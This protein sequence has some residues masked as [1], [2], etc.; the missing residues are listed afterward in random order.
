MQDLSQA[1]RKTFPPFLRLLLT[2][3]SIN[4]QCLISMK[5]EAIRHDRGALPGEGP[6]AVSLQEQGTS[7]VL[8]A[9]P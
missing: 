5:K 6:C 8:S 2:D 9:F 3:F 7:V 1:S 4:F